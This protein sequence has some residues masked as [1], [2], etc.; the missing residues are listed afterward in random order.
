MVGGCVFRL[1]DE[2]RKDRGGSGDDHVA[3]DPSAGY[4]DLSLSTLLVPGSCQR[5]KLMWGGKLEREEE[6]WEQGRQI[7][8]SGIQVEERPLR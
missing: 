2:R 3:I 5:L 6:G 4:K 8:V 7:R 1:K